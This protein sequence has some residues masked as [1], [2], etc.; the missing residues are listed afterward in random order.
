MKKYLSKIGALALA[1]LM[2]LAFSSCA[3]A[4]GDNNSPRNNTLRVYTWFDYQYDNGDNDSL[5][6]DFNEYYRELS[7][8]P[9]FNV[10]F[11]YFSTVEEMLTKIET[12]KEDFDLACP[13]DYMIQQMLS[14]D[15]LKPIDIDRLENYGNLSPFIVDSHNTF[16]AAAKKEGDTNTYSVSYMWG[17]MGTLYNADRMTDQ[18][19]QSLAKDW[20]QFFDE[21]NRGKVLIK[22]SMRDT[23]VL[24]SIVANLEKLQ[25]FTPGS[26]E[27][28]NAVTE[29]INDV[30]IENVLATEKVLNDMKK[31]VNVAFEVDDGKTEMAVGKRWMN[32]AWSGDAIWA[33]LEAKQQH[34]ANLA[35]A[36]PK[37]GSNLWFD[38]WVIPKYAVNTDAAHAFLDF[39]LDSDVAI[40]NMEYIG[41]TSGVATPAVA[42]W[43]CGENEDGNGLADGY[44]EEGEIFPGLGY[45]DDVD[46]SYFFA[47]GLVDNAEHFSVP[48]FM[49]PSKSEIAVC[50]IMRDFGDQ[51][52]LVSNMWARMKTSS[53]TGLL[54]AVGVILLLVIIAAIT[55][56]IIKKIK[57][58]KKKAAKQLTPY[59]R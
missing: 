47:D 35:Y 37:I 40:A 38:G 55:L 27:H 24:A 52:I 36:I 19:K 45:K 15:L 9:N 30:S 51:T 59:R 48:T 6:H 16:E 41:Y 21:Q 56:Y 18:Q 31:A 43:I 44:E 39:I 54:I 8:N 17:T 58:P 2:L 22:D 50:A 23:Y 29:V 42:E 14:K 25:G 53:L 34:N 11:T 20:S 46:M 5:E 57:A 4:E 33:I 26:L 10:E 13:S 49:Y 28:L 1:T 32:L 3:V 12:G 7:G